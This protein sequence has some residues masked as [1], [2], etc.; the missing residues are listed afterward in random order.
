MCINTR[1]FFFNDTATT[2]IYTLSLH[3]ALPIC[4]C[5]N[6]EAANALGIL[7]QRRGISRKTSCNGSLREHSLFGSP[8][9]LSV[10]QGECYAAF[11]GRT[12]HLSAGSAALLPA[13]AFP[14]S[15]GSLARSERGH[16]AAARFTGAVS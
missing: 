8:L 16:R 11:Y 13:G 10:H 12:G 7:S 15:T 3:D 9:R 1:I 14:A 4:S 2:E 6:T 5:A